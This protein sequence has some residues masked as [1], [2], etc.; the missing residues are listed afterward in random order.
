MTTL[1]AGLIEKPDFESDVPREL[2]P[3][4]SM[5]DGQPTALTYDVSTDG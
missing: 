4:R 2:F 5:P 3:A 1:D